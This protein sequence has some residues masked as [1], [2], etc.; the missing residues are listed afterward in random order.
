MSDQ[1]EG[2]MTPEDNLEHLEFMNPLKEDA[3][4]MH[5]MFVA[6]MKAGFQERQALQLVAFMIDESG[7][8]SNVQIVI[9]QDL[10]DDI[11]ERLEEDDGQDS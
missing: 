9:N 5:E 8:R 4:N 2:D 7:D 11:N 1:E 10:I 6:L 3:A